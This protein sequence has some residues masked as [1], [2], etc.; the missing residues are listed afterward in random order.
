MGIGG[1]P[2]GVLAAAGIKC[3]GGDMQCKMWPRDEKERKQ[4]IA[5][6][7]EKDLDRIFWPTT[8]PTEKTLSFPPPASATARYCAASVPKGTTA[9]THSI[10]MRAKSQTV[11]FIRATPRLHK[12]PFVCARTTASTDLVISAFLLH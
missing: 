8:W 6:G 4:L 5:D 9:I 7:N 2:E 3:L 11:R 10:F 12:K 1:S